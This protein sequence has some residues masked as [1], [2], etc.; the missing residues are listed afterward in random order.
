ML[1]AGRVPAGAV[2]PLPDQEILGQFEVAARKAELAEG[3]L[4]RGLDQVPLRRGM[5]GMSRVSCVS[6]TRPR[7]DVVV[8][9]H[10]VQRRHADDP[11]VENIDILQPQGSDKRQVGRQPPPQS[12][13]AAGARF[14]PIEIGAVEVV[15]AGIEA[16]VRSQEIRLGEADQVSL[17][18]WLPGCASMR[19][20]WP[21]PRQARPITKS[22]QLVGG[23]PMSKF[24]SCSTILPMRPALELTVTPNM[25]WPVRVSSTNTSTGAGV[26]K[27]SGEIGS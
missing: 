6:V 23:L 27:A 7:V 8:P 3:L 9:L 20:P 15:G 24:R 21:P 25:N 4:E 16:D 26:A 18:R 10:F 19:N 2:G 13:P 5:N 12:Q 11:Q 1:N 14:G 17:Q 22:S